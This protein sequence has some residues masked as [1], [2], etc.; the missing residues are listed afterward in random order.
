MGA[1]LMALAPAW[2]LHSRTG[3][4]TIIAASFYAC[5]I[6][7]YLL[8]QDA[9]AALSLCRDPFRRRDL[10]HLFE[11]PTD[12]GGRGRVAGA[13]R[14]PLSR[15]ELAHHVARPAADCPVPRSRPSASRPPT[16]ACSSTH[17]RVL[18]SYW[19]YDRPLSA[20]VGAIGQDLRLWPES[21]LLVHPQSGRPGAPPDAGIRQHELWLLPFFLLGVGLS[22]WRAVK[23]SVPHRVLLVAILASPAG[24]ALAQIALTRVMAFVVPATLLIA[25]GIEALLGLVKRRG[26]EF[27]L[28]PVLFIVLSAPSFLDVA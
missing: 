20:E 12:H 13:N 26:A 14:Y 6:L 16:P 24:A 5:F 8:I 15:Q 1:L 23:G 9:L 19:F 11:R 27:V 17:L 22:L 4:E 28:A 18:D 2:F 7:F 21:G 10:L 3:F 25:V